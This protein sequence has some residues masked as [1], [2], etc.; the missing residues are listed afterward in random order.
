M[1]EHNQVPQ[2]VKMAVSYWPVAVYRRSAAVGQK[3]TVEKRV[4]TRCRDDNLPA[5]AKIA[6]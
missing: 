5:T 2:S 3:Q 4:H 1:V 6:Y